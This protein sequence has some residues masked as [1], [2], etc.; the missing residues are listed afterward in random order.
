MKKLECI[1]LEVQSPSISKAYWYLGMK[2][3]NIII[4]N[5]RGTLRRVLEPKIIR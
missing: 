1:R 3:K 2:I 4:R 5:G